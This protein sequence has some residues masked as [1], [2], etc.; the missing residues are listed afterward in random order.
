MHVD[1][2]MR[3]QGAP[4]GRAISVITSLRLDHEGTAADRPVRQRHDNRRQAGP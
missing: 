3:V 4:A 2:W 1:V